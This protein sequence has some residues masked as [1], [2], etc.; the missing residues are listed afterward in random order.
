MDD[1]I[2]LLIIAFSIIIGFFIIVS[3]FMVPCNS[4]TEN[5]VNY[6]QLPFGNIYSGSDAICYSTPDNNTS[7]ISDTKTEKYNLYP[8]INKLFNPNNMQ[9]LPSFYKII[10]Y[11]KPYNYPRKQLIDYPLQHFHHPNP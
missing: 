4:T 2:K 9:C 10:R 1:Q 3:L 6:M 7:I 5:W 8:S 11:N